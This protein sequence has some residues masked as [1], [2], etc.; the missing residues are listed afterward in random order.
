MDLE[1]LI[2]VLEEAYPDTVI[3][4]RELSSYEQGKQHGC[5]DIIR[6]I[7]SLLENEGD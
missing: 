3:T 6:Y 2:K 4:T 7:K 5:I 1:K